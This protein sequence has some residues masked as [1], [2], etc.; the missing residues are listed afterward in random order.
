MSATCPLVPRAFTLT[1]AFTKNP[2]KVSSL[3]RILT[4]IISEECKERSEAGAARIE[5][6]D[7]GSG[8][9]VERRGDDVI[10]EDELWTIAKSFLAQPEV[11]FNGE[12]VLLLIRS[13]GK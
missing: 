12:P 1:A 7:V 4:K 3:H 5:L 13:F 10:G 9:M 8:A 6:I 2:E 11:K